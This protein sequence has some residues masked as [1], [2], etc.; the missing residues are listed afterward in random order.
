MLT[1]LIILPD[2]T[3]LASGTGQTNNIRTVTLTECVNSGEELTLGSVCAAMAE[4]TVQTP[5][6]AL[7]LTAGD[8]VTLFKVD[9]AGVRHQMG[10]FTLEKPTRPSANILKLTGYD[11]ITRLDKDLTTWLKSLDS[12]P[13]TLLDF[14]GMVCTEC[15]LNL[16]TTDIPNGDYLVRQFEKEATGRKLMEWVGQI[17]CRFCLATPYGDV[18]LAWYTPSGV[19]ITPSGNPYIISRSLSYEDYTVAPIDAVQVKLTS[20]VLVPTAVAGD[21]CYIISG[22]PMFTTITDAVLTAIKDEMNAVLYTPCKVAIPAM[23]DIHAGHTVE[24]TD[25]NGV[26]ITALVMTKTNK[27]QR[28]TLEC[29]GSYRRDSAD[30]V[31]NPTD[32]QKAATQEANAYNAGKQAVK[33][34]TQEEVFNKLT[35]GGELQGLYIQDD[36]LY[37]NAEFVQIV[38]LVASSIVSGMLKSVDGLAYFDLDNGLF[39]IDG[40]S[41]EDGAYTGIRLKNDS[42]WGISRDAN[43]SISSTFDI[44]ATP[45]G[46]AIT[47]GLLLPSGL[48]I[49]L[50]STG[51]LQLGTA[52][53][54]VT[55][56]GSDIRIV[57]AP[58][59][60]GSKS[61]KWVDSGNGYSYLVGVEEETT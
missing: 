42:I 20:G 28:D 26:T 61:L 1:N 41:D 19:T 27:G 5:M 18:E 23:L 22:N 48:P 32:S 50:W 9:D 53:A 6:G 34:E 30:A 8:E 51:G 16:V 60:I 4:A 33:E 10:L 40:E 45:V 43:G 14:A 11:R 17:C 31:N 29:T 36:K 35:N 3:E 12:W 54:P 38:N 39:A 58:L 59:Y 49:K 46:V 37:I 2:G 15:G 55:I 7:A 47:D 25:R 44:R 13:Y 21:N 52:G 57:G 24:I 56:T